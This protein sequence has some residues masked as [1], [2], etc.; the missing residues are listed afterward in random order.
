[1]EVVPQVAKFKKILNASLLT[2]KKHFCGGQRRV[3]LSLLMVTPLGFAFKSYPGL[4]NW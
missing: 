3:I 2:G 4:G 1:L